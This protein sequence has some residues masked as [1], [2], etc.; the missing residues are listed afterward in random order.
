[1]EG[2]AILKWCKNLNIDWGSSYYK[3]SDNSIVK[4]QIWD[5]SGRTWARNSIETYYKG[6]D[7]IIL[8]YD[9]SYK[10]TFNECKNYYCEKIKQLCKNNIKVMLIGN[11]KDLEYKR[12]IS[13]EE[14]NSFA[15]E[16][17]YIYMEA[18]CQRNENVFET[19]EKAI[20]MALIEK[21]K[22]N[23]NQL[24]SKNENQFKSKKK[25]D[26]LLI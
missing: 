21:K 9:I 16:N 25:E 1:M 10:D 26:C 6:V 8:I 20:E 22:E 15:L 12:E 2:K 4:V 18:S 19:F 3:L 24:K 5:T 13:F 11:K 17:N 14:A 23:G 7:F